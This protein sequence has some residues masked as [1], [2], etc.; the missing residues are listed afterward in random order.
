MM[1]IDISSA[2]AGLNLILARTETNN[3]LSL[4]GSFEKNVIQTRIRETKI[5]PDEHAW[6][7]WQ[8][9]T[10]HQR[11]AKGNVPQGLLW[12]TGNLLNSIRF[13]E[14]FGQVEIGTDVPY[15]HELQHGRDGSA[16]QRPMVPRE[17][18]GWQQSDFPALEAM[19][20]GHLETA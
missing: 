7:P 3:F 11:E 1:T 20:V 4:V 10:R 8:P 17:F 15:A 18:I 16:G 9:F 12:D 14:S 6:A 19:L 2:I 5:D 13:E